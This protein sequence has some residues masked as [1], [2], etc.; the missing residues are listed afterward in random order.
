ILGT[1][2]AAMA[3]STSGGFANVAPL[4]WASSPPPTATGSSS[5][6]A[7]A[8]GA[9][10][11]GTLRGK[12]KLALGRFEHGEWVTAGGSTSGSTADVTHDAVKGTVSAVSATSITVK[13][14]D[15]FS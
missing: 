14:A 15:G 7:G 2:A 11:A 9:K 1:G 8:T 5:A 13:A 4:T 10:A 6:A 3:E 12:L